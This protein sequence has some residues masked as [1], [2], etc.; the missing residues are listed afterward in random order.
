MFSLLESKEEISKAHKKLVASIRR[1]F[2]TK[3]VKNIGYPGGTTFNATV[4]TNGQYWFW[5]KDHDDRSEPNPR[6]LNWFGL[7]NE[8]TGLQ[9]TVEI[10]TPYKGQNGQIAGYFARDNKSGAI[11]LMHS[12]RVG[13]GTKGVGKATF[14]AWSEHQLTEVAD[15]KGN[16]YEGI[17]VMPIEGIA[18]SRPAITY[19]DT[20]VGFKKAVRA[21][22]IETPE[23]KQKLKNFQDYYDESRGHRKGKRSA[24]IDYL[25]RHGD[26]VSAL[27]VWRKSQQLPNDGRI[28]KNVL[29]DLGVEVKNSL[30]EVYEVKTSTSRSDIYTALGQLFV[31]G[32]DNNCQKVM[33]LP[34]NEPIAADLNSALQTLNINIVRFE[35]DEDKATII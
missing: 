32:T 2:K 7:F 18:A 30:I 29:I 3:S 20:I 16:I 6:K 5:T 31:H 14:L 25:S 1:D 11:Y 4:H 27:H 9:I 35:L 13:G 33:V 22:E 12:G 19:I 8:G 26:V 10:N 17:V 21:G 15:S 24:T 28:V 34:K 23:F